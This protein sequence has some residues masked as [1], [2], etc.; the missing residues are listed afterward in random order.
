[1]G[2]A[3]VSPMIVDL[4]I[5]LGLASIIIAIYFNYFISGFKAL[6]KLHPTMLTLISIGSG[7]LIFMASMSLS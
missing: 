3:D 6:F 1:V 5:E 7:S 2:L 4:A